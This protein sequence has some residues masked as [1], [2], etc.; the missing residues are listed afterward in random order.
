MSY[1]H[2]Q[3]K[4][5]MGCRRRTGKGCLR[6]RLAGRSGIWGEC[7]A[8]GIKFLSRNLRQGLCFR[9]LSPGEGEQIS[10]AK[11]WG[12]GGR[13]WQQLGS[14][15]LCPRKAGAAGASPVMGWP[16]PGSR[17]Q[18]AAEDLT[19]QSPWTA[20]APH[21][22]RRDCVRASSPFPSC[23]MEG[24]QKWTG[25]IQNLGSRPAPS[26]INCLISLWPL[27]LSLSSPMQAQ[28]LVCEHVDQHWLVIRWVSIPGTA[29]DR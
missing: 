25:G 20:L 27:V 10:A 14:P 19:I 12:D 13:A 22:I 18:C 15:S 6:A 7:P 17:L 9:S 16:G 24:V 5:E 29:S 26:V 1:G 4:T 2:L 23:V 8:L 3:R 11:M 21:T 28:G